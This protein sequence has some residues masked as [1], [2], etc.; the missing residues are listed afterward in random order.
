MLKKNMSP[1]EAHIKKGNDDGYLTIEVT[2]VFSV[3]L[4]SLLLILFVGIVLYQ[5]V[6]LQ[7]AAERTA[8]RG[9]LMYASGLKDMETG[10]KTSEDYRNSNPYRYLFGN[11]K[12]AAVGRMKV[13]MGEKIGL[14]NLYT[15]DGATSE[16]DI[17]GWLIAQKASAKAANQ[18]HMPILAVAETFGVSTIKIDAEAVAAVTDTPEF[19][20]TADF[21]LDE[22]NRFKAARDVMEKLGE[23]KDKISS[24]ANL[25]NIEGD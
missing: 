14:H 2:I 8:G 10:M 20:R 1:C 18:Y 7:S 6:Q 3:I 21:I 23:L 24:T 16:A 5:E 11:G 17:T 12:D 4:F 9:A 25:L 19:I 22:V 15:G 13:Y